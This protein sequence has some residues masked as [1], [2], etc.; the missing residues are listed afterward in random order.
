M[1]DL[2]KELLECR[3]KWIIQYVA[4]VIAIYRKYQGLELD[5]SYN[6]LF[7]ICRNNFSCTVEEEEIIYQLVD[8]L[9]NQEYDLLIANKDKLVLVDLMENSVNESEG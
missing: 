7:S 8:D 2:E 4:N 6:Q 9:L 5:I 3:L 1:N